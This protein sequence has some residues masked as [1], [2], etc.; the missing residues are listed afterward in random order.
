MATPAT[1]EDQP[2]SAVLW[3]W[4]WNAVR[5]V[6]GYVLIA[7]GLVLI[8]VAYL[9]VS[10]EIY[11]A[12][13]LP[14][15]V[16]GGLTG[17]AAVTLGSRLLLIEDLRRDSGRLDTLERAITELHEV[18]L[19]RPDAPSRAEDP[20]VRRAEVN[21]YDEPP[22]LALVGGDSFHRE[23]CPLVEGKSTARPVTTAAQRKG[24]R[25]CLMCQ[26]LAAGV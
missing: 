25:P 20:S 24:L 5:P 2:D 14:Y 22:L 3:R 16:S 26:P 1:P 18:L 11:V 4:V 7:L 13:Q 9:G 19:S 6:L 10:R 21:G 15:L 8:L 23:D 12:R 17:L